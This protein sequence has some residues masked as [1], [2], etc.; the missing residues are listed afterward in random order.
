MN[1]PE[2]PR[3]DSQESFVAAL[4]WGFDAALA[5]GAR[6][7]LC[8]DPGFE[9]WPLDEP[10]LLQALGAWMR[11]PQRRLVFLAATYDGVPRCH[12][13]FNGWRRDWAHTIS[14]MQ[15]PTELAADLPT[16]LL[17]NAAVS[18][19]L[20]DAVHWRG[21]AQ[22]DVRAAHLWRDRI[23]VFMQRSEAAFPVNI[24]GL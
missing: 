24:L 9:A 14:F 11:L 5:Q 8:V 17:D 4:R 19:Q 22:Q 18:V 12:P 7:I 13:R 10:E 21:R 15:A 2:A 16:L 20:I 23:D 3:I 1:T 6:Q